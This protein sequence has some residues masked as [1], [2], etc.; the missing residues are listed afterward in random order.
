MC[1]THASLSHTQQKPHSIHNY[2]WPHPH[3]VVNHTHVPQHSQ[4]SGVYSHTHKSRPQATST[5][6]T[7]MPHSHATPTHTL[8]PLCL[9]SSIDKDGVSTGALHCLPPHYDG[10]AAE[11]LT[12]NHRGR[13]CGCGHS[14]WC[15]PHGRF[16][17]VSC[18]RPTSYRLLYKEVHTSE[19]AFSSVW[20]ASNFDP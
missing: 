7:H 11:L 14:R 12:A 6:H 2:V 3:G 5:S 19:Y 13:E 9:P 10:H 15:C 4:I 18:G 8:F 16:I 17:G 1:H 20:S